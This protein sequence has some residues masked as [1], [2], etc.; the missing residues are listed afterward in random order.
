MFVE[1]Q[2]SID[3]LDFKL[4]PYNAEKHKSNIY[5]I[6]YNKLY[7]NFNSL[8]EDLMNNITHKCLNIFEKMVHKEN[9]ISM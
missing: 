3:K 7:Y 4:L 2:E 5:D 9:T 8:T 1:N 6:I